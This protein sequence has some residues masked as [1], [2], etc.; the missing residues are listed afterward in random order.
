MLLTGTGETASF[1]FNPPLQ[2]TLSP[3]TPEHPIAGLAVNGGFRLSS[4]DGAP[5]LVVDVAQDTSDVVLTSSAP[6]LGGTL[7]VRLADG[8]TP[9]VGDAWTIMSGF[10]GQ[11]TG[12][13]ESTSVEGGTDFGFEVDTAQSGVVV[14]RL[15]QVGTVDA[16][17][18]AP[19]LAL[20]LAAYPNPVV[21]RAMVEVSLPSAGP[22]R[23]AVYDL[24][25][26]EVARLHDS[27]LAEGIH[28][29]PFETRNLAA[30]VY[31]VRLEATGTVRTR[32]LTVVR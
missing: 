17:D 10:G 2:G 16:E 30:G 25:G 8:Y 12:A 6:T 22:V 28:R 32:Q 18:E 11:A 13:F 7:V 5:R 3:G 9:T 27:P 19:V 31:V 1:Y 4:T 21:G 23:S 20:A 26:R 24:L 29:L 15:T 14:L